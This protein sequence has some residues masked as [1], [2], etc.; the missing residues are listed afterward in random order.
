MLN[1][2]NR[3]EDGK[4]KINTLNLQILFGDLFEICNSEKEI[5]FVLNNI[6]ECAECIADEIMEEKDLI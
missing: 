2:L 1:I 4:L 6:V 5:N 3:N